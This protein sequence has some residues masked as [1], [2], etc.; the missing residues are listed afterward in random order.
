MWVFIREGS[1]SQN[2]A[3]ADPDGAAPRHR[4]RR[5]SAATTA[6]PTRS[7]S[8]ATST[9]ACGSRSPPAC[10]VEDALVLAT[11][12]GA[13]Y[14]NFH[15]LGSLG[16]GLPGRHP[17][18]RPPR[19]AGSRP[20]CGSAAGSSPST[21]SSSPARCPTR[22]RPSG[23]CR[24][25]HL[26]HRPTAAELDL[27]PSA[28]SGRARVIGVVAGQ[29]H[30][31]RRS[32]STHRP[33][34]STSRASP[35]SSATARPGRIGLGYVSGFGLARGAIASTVAHDA[36]NCMVVGARDGSDGPRDMAVA[37]AR[38]AEIGGGQVAVRRR[39]VL[40]EVRLPIGGLM[41]DRPAGE[42]ADALAAARRHWPAARLGVTIAAP[43]MKLSFLGLSVIPQLRI[44]DKG[45]V[46]VDR[47]E[48]TT[49]DA[50]GRPTK[51]PRGEQRRSRMV[52]DASRQRRA[53]AARR[54][55]PAEPGEARRRI[56][57][58]V[59]RSEA[60]GPRR[61]RGGSSERRGADGVVAPEGVPE[62][63]ARPERPVAEG[64]ES[65][66]GWGAGRR[67]R[68]PSPGP[69]HRSP[70]DDAR[71]GWGG[72]GH[73]CKDG[74]NRQAI[75]RNLRQRRT[76]PTRCVVPHL[77]PSDGPTH[78][79]SAARR[80]KNLAPRARARRQLRE[81]GR[82][83]RSAC[84][85]ELI[86]RVPMHSPRCSDHRARPVQRAMLPPM[87]DA[88]V[89][90]MREWGVVAAAELERIVVCR[91]ISTTPFSDART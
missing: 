17:V 31:A 71:S 85:R 72:A 83:V 49:V 78:P 7:V 86:S 69:T 50:A 2:L 40:A 67:K 35:C 27:A 22:R 74:L 28:R 5:R 6:S 41:S 81:R 84:T 52:S 15:H 37:A 63:R 10:R 57:G 64:A 79:E 43:F 21:A 75:A 33:G 65:G 76:V 80:Q 55:R 47:F 59:R 46:D 20:G 1:A 18:L 4:S 56:R 9:T 19:L 90:E 54:H 26:Q 24:S 14:H 38:L 12:N 87:A 77:N 82:R 58:I 16:P 11:V 34:A 42:V 30:D 88:P 29:P 3:R 51:A 53:S 62:Q 91:P 44:T 70:E 68:G 61:R 23:C 48:L 89:P 8:S 66:I 39:R 36:H 45:L 25:V 13:E 32:C 60:D 73:R